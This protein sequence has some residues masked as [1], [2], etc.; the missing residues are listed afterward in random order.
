MSNHRL[1]FRRSYELVF[2]PAVYTATAS[3]TFGL[4]SIVVTFMSSS[5][6]YNEKNV[7]QIDISCSD[8]SNSNLSRQSCNTQDY[9]ESCV[10]EKPSEMRRRTTKSPSIAEQNVQV[11]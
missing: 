6:L 5:S 3:V 7:F 9:R 8:F 4:G 1:L 2:V 11:R 10:I